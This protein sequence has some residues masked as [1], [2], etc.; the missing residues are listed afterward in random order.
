[1][2]GRFHFNRFVINFNNYIFCHKKELLW[3]ASLMCVRVREGVSLPMGSNTHFCPNRIEIDP[4]NDAY[5]SKNTHISTKVPENRPRTPLNV[6]F[7]EG[8]LRAEILATPN[9]RILRRISTF[10]Q[11]LVSLVWPV[12]A[13]FH[14]LREIR[15][16]GQATPQGP[17]IGVHEAPLVTN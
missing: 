3:N 5:S 16:F 14:I 8:P 15:P 13:F 2:E 11:I 9:R 12:W 10:W 6:G 7:G 1:M 4:Q 17:R